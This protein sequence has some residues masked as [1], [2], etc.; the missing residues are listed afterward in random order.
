VPKTA[1]VIEQ[2]IVGARNGSG[3]RVLAHSPDFA[4]DWHSEA[5]KI[6]SAFGERAEGTACPNAMFAHPFLKDRV[7]IVQVADQGVDAV[8]RPGSLAFRFLVLSRSAYV[9]LSGDPFQIADSFP[10]YW[11]VKNP[12][13]TLY[14]SQEAVR[15]RSVEQVV[16]VL[17]RG[18]GPILLGG[19]QA[20]V[21]GGRL[22]F[23]RSA[24]DTEL[25]RSLWTLL[26]TSTRCGLWPATFVF[27]NRLQV[28]AAV[29]PHAAVQEFRDFVTEEQAGNYPEGHYELQVQVAAEAGDQRGLDA[30]FA[31]RSRNETWRLGLILLA[32]MVVLVP[33]MGWL[34]SGSSTP[35]GPRPNLSPSSEYP[36][37]SSADRKTLTQAL[38]DLAK[39]WHVTVPKNARAER[40]LAALDE[41]LGPGVDGR[42][43]PEDV[44]QGKIQRRLRAVLWKHGSPDYA[45]PDLTLID[46][47]KRLRRLGEPAAVEKP[48]TKDDQRR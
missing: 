2:A 1:I 7:A 24:P 32:A 3:L 9:E 13:P 12:L 10:P 41:H 16:N 30:L 45:V 22:I 35:A 20:L 21:D 36:T 29:A 15:P 11:E 33:F 47:V 14:L 38:N 34:N 6:S 18:D 28:S 26:P 37:I 27:A 19:C 42:E 25:L 23:E 44:T 31:R 43:A 48:P 8:G 17:K 4:N 39:E 40:I 46:Q 5:E